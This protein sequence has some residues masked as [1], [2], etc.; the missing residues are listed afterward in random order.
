[1]SFNYNH[2]KMSYESMLD[3]LKEQFFS[4]ELTCMPITVGK[5]YEQSPVRLM[6]VGRAVN[7]W[8]DDWRTGTT[9]QLVE[10]VFEHT[11]DMSVIMQGVTEYKSGDK[12]CTYN[13]NRSPF[14]QLCRELLKQHG[15]EENWADYVAWT[16]LYKVSYSKAGNPDNKL[17]CKTIT[18]CADIL[19]YEIFCERPTHIVFVT[20]DW[21]IKPTGK[22]IN[23]TAFIDK[24]GID[25]YE[26]TNS[27]LVIG[28]GVVGNE[29]FNFLNSP[30]P[31][32]VITK[33]PESA[34]VSRAEHAK[35]I[36]DA[37]A[38]IEKGGQN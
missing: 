19:F 17:I 28:S 22:Y 9:E 29:Y 6:Y 23:Q 16:N 7:G 8:N 37:F 32:Y 18:D 35:A 31:K 13:Y 33:R 3:P 34:K 25:T 14:W 36:F 12:I 15:I 2:M 11:Q 38:D 5:K 20:D 26:E 21:W 4:K 1:M 30:R 10:Q 24:L 27:N